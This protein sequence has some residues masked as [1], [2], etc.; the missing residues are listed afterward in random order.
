MSSSAGPRRVRRPRKSSALTS[1]GK[2]VSSTGTAEGA[3]TGV[4]GAVFVSGDWE[5]MALIWGL[6]LQNERGSA[7]WPGLVPAIHALPFYCVQ[8]VDARDKP[9]HD[10]H[11]HSFLYATAS[12]HQARM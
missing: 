11:L 8:D 9:G 3:R 1:K 5:T 2:T 12:K 7:S 4:S 6:G 10:E